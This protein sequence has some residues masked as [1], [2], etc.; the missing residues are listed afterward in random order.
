MSKGCLV[1]FISC[2]FKFLCDYV[3]NEATFRQMFLL[4]F[5][6]HCFQKNKFFL[7]DKR[8]RPGNEAEQ[9]GWEPE[10]RGRMRSWG[11][12]WWA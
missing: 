5:G 3:P 11:E 8:E 1:I 10:E 7:D 6:G 2:L 9:R 12:V 4:T